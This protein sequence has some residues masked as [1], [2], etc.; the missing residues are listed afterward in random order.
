MK[1]LLFLLVISF[2]FSCTKENVPATIEGTWAIIES[3]IGN[4]TGVEVMRY[5]PSSEMTLQFAENNMLVLTGGN[6]GE[7][8]SP[9]WQYDRY[10]ILPNSMIRFFQSFGPQEMEAHYTIDGELYLNY[11]WARCGH[12]EKFVR[13][14]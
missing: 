1:R 2:L 8:Q 11:P 3:N 5:A 13:V 14:K 4:G 6:P 7:A 10:K 9:L 12:E